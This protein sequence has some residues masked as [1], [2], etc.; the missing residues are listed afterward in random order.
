MGMEES[1][2]HPAL[3][4]RKTS[5]HFLVHKVFRK[6]KEQRKAAR[7]PCMLPPSPFPVCVGSCSSFPAGASGNVTG[8]RKWKVWEERLGMLSSAPPLVHGK[9]CSSRSP[10]QATAHEE[11]CCSLWQDTSLPGAGSQL[12]G[13][14][15]L[16]SII[17]VPGMFYLGFAWNHFVLPI[18]LLGIQVPFVVPF[19]PWDS[20]LDF[21][22][23]AGERSPLPA[24]SAATAGSPR[25]WSPPPASRHRR[26][27]LH[28]LRQTLVQMSGQ[29]PRPV[30][31]KESTCCCPVTTVPHYQVQTE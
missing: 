2:T 4:A 17:N 10:G 30:L 28:L 23:P 18:N 14:S 1:S 25:C 7:C 16:T 20:T 5:P 15:V 22:T 12:A 6:H 19:P 11:A 3:K 8:E 13:S 27:C 29:G 24:A 26:G 21:S 31:I 9:G